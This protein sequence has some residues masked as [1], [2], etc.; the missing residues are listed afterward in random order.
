MPEW[1]VCLWFVVVLLT[2]LVL[3][4]AGGV[5][6]AFV[7]Y[8]SWRRDVSAAVESAFE[9]SPQIEPPL[10]LPSTPPRRGRRRRQQE[11]TSTLVEFPADVDWQSGP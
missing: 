1:L 2:A 11:A 6:V 9:P 8:Q 3:V 5:G 7:A 10:A 4:L